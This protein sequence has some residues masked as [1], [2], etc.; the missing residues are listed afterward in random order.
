MLQAW[1][2]QMELINTKEEVRAL[3]HQLAKVAHLP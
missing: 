2:L 1:R 3:R